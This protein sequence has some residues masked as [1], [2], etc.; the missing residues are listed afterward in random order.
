MRLLFR[1]LRLCSLMCVLAGVL[2]A[3]TLPR[4]SALSPDLDDPA[5]LGAFLDPLI[6]EG[7]QEQ[8]IPGL[9]IAVVKDG[10]LLFS[11]GYGYADIEKRTPVDPARTE[12]R[13]A[14]I[15]KLFT[16]TAVLQAVEQGRVD[17]QTD[18]NSYLKEVRI[19]ATFARPITL[20]DLLTHTPGF[21]DEYIGKSARTEADQQPLG[22]FLAHA[23]PERLVPPGEVYSYSNIGNAIAG[24]VVESVEGRDYAAYAAD[25]IF[26]PLGMRRT[27]YRLPAGL[28]PDLAV[29]YTLEG[30]EFRRN[31]FDVLNDYPGGQAISTANDMAR[32]M[33]AYLQEGRLGDHRIVRD[34]TARAMMEP[35][36]THH[37]G[38]RSTVGY[39][40]HQF[41]AR[42]VRVVGHD[43]GY[44]GSS[45]RLWLFP[46]HGVGIFIAANLMV[47]T[48]NDMISR[49]FVDR[50]FP[51]PVPD[52]VSYTLEPVPPH[53]PDVARFGGTYRFTR[54]AHRTIDKCGTLIGMTGY[55]MQIGTTQDGMILMQTF[56]GT[57]R[58]MVQV[59]P[60]FFRS[61]DDDYA[62]AFR[63]KDG[64][65]THLFT[66]GT[67]SFERIAWYERSSL[68]RWFIPGALVLFSAVGAGTF[69]A[70][71]RRRTPQPAP[72]LR[73]W[74][75][76]SVNSFCLHFAGLG[77]MFLL[78][79][80]RV[81]LTIGFA[82]GLPWTMSI[83]Q[84]IPLVGVVLLAAFAVELASTVRSGSLPLRV[85]TGYLLLFIVETGYV[86]ALN[87]WNLLGY[88]Y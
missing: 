9:A 47:P 35:Q 42:G 19:P 31:P 20:R 6:T 61:I 71:R 5:E 7:M 38:L 57:S 36:F 76:W 13:I 4:V 52:T 67:S 73:R 30:T 59:E 85:W 65:P 1:T 62:C 79:I 23:I 28:V 80:P 33:I 53:D 66:N 49:R 70:G 17:L 82:Y 41:N 88:R 21:D 75:L 51:P 84:T 32:F 14:S 72:R 39:G 34:T 18:V 48:L 15:S 78:V 60:G 46:E 77:I 54:Y 45:T 55:E 50:F 68:H 86:W 2:R 11:K 83:V 16:A 24:Y 69:V 22:R 26:G 81:E 12:F 64:M 40:F 25:S 37:A 63:M 87:Y 3:Q 56:R 43:G 58:R 27:S 74:A 29:C 8:H 44:I 10:D